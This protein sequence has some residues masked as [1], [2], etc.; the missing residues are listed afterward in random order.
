[1]VIDADVAQSRANCRSSTSHRVLS[2]NS[3]DT[4]FIT[5]LPFPFAVERE[6]ADEMLV[7]ALRAEQSA[8]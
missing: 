3:N 6:F 7:T 2:K 1:V 5:I 8:F 4:Q